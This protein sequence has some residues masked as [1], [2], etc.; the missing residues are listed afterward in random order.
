MAMTKKELWYSCKGCYTGVKMFS[1]C[2]LDN[3]LKRSGMSIFDE[4]RMG[5]YN[6]NTLRRVVAYTMG[7]RREKVDC[8]FCEDYNEKR[9]KC[10]WCNGKGYKWK[11]TK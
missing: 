9:L 8:H 11:V 1:H 4:V 2:V 10:V 7:E 5:T 6:H 3:G